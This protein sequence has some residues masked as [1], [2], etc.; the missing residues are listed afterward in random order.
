MQISGHTRARLGRHPLDSNLPREIVPH[1]LPEGER[2]C[3]TR[4]PCAG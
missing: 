3:H 4:Q 2:F 1:E